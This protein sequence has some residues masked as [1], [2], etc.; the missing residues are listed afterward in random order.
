MDSDSL[1]ADGGSQPVDLSGRRGRIMDQLRVNLRKHP[2]T[3]N[4]AYEPTRD[5][6]DS[7]LVADFNT[8]IYVDGLIEAGTAHLEVTWWTHPIG[9][10]DQFK[11]PLYRIRGLRLRLAPSAP[12]R[13]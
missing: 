8:D 1:V 10:D 4:V 12:S 7:K 2:A 13:A 3:T 6:L 9:T 11:I 5:G